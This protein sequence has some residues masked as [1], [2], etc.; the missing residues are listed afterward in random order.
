MRPVASTMLMQPSTFST[1]LLW[2]SIPRA[3]RRKLVFAWPHMRAAFSMATTGIPVIWEVHS[4]VQ[5]F[6]ASSAASKPFVCAFTKSQSMRFHLCKRCRMPLVRA[7]SVPGFRGSIRSAVR[8]RGVMRGSTTM[9]LAP[10]SLAL[11]M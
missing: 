6:T 9:S 5:S 7:A 11:Q 10:L 4:G 1:P 3:C 8:A 2:C